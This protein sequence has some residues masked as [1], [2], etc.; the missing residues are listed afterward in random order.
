MA[1]K[2]G[3]VGKVLDGICREL[4][5]LARRIDARL[6]QAH[7]F[8]EDRVLGRDPECE[9]AVEPAL[10]RWQIVAQA[11]AFGFQREPGS[12]LEVRAGD[13]LELAGEQQPVPAREGVLGIVALEIVGR[14]EQEL[15][16]DRGNR[17]IIQSR[18]HRDPTLPAVVTF[19][20][21]IAFRAGIDRGRKL[22]VDSERGHAARA[23]TREAFPGGAGIAGLVDC[24]VRGDVED[25][26]VGRVQCDGDDR[27]AFLLAAEGKEEEGE[28][29]QSECGTNQHDR[30]GPNH[31]IRCGVKKEG[32]RRGPRRS[33]LLAPLAHGINRSCKV[34]AVLG[35]CAQG[36]SSW[37]RL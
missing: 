19:K 33:P 37:S 20:D 29:R 15:V 18:A 31:R 30:G 14:I 21:R 17:R 8:I 35:A 22:W 27:L 26:G 10:D 11:A 24:V 6:D 13:R 32:G 23:E 7:I 16:D 25:L 28:R 36:R 1:V 12:L 34:A 4:C 9:D 5:L 3:S 2:V